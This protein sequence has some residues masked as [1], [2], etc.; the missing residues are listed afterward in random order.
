MKDSDM[1]LPL[2]LRFLETI[3]Q[4]INNVVSMTVVCAAAGLY[5]RDVKFRSE[6]ADLLEKLDDIQAKNSLSGI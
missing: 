6:G 1:V 5:Y 2:Y 4:T 3:S